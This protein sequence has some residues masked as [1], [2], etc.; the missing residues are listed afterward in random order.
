MALSPTP[1]PRL[2]KLLLLLGFMCI[3]AIADAQPA[4]RAVLVEHFT[5]SRCSICAAR[6]PAF[7]GTLRQQPGV[8]HVAYHPSSPYAACVFSQQNRVENDARTNFYGVYG[9]TPRLVINGAVIPAGQNYADPAMYAPFQGQTSPFAITTT[10]AAQ[11]TDSVRVTVQLTTVA[12]HSY[13]TLTLYVPL[14]ED[15]VFYA[16]PN[17]EPRHYDVFR[18]SFTGTAPLTVTPATPVG[19]T[20]TVRRTLYRDPSWTADRLYAIAI[21]QDAGRA[22][23]QAAASPLL[24]SAVNGLPEAA[25]TT[26]RAYPNPVTDKLLLT[27]TEHLRALSIT[28]ALGQVVDQQAYAEAALDLAHLPPGLYVLRAL[29]EAGAPVRFR[30]TKQ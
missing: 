13:P 30:F 18:R 17:G 12:A 4:P 19:G 16:A 6:N 23:V 22:V 14:V 21:V 5:N 25:E 24:N 8:L 1:L 7:Y 11:G 20:T 27:G 15:T 9:G 26:L 3:G 28:N 2:V 10:L 29:T